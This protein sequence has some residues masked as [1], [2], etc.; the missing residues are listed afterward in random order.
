MSQQAEQAQNDQM[1][2]DEPTTAPAAAPAEVATESVEPKA[3]SQPAVEEK[4]TAA[5][6]TTTTTAN[7]DETPQQQDSSVKVE[8]PVSA[9]PA[10]EITTNGGGQAP[11]SGQ[12]F[13]GVEPSVDKLIEQN[14]ASESSVQASKKTKVDLASLPTRAY[15]DQTI[16]PILLQGMSVL[17]KERPPNPIE[18]LASY[19]LKNKDKFE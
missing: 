16:V 6:V 5:E 8:E 11:T 10:A 19:L 7:V 13:G 14:E 9:A 4:P 17:A 3:F 12:Q 2:V 15:L 18:Y 1:A